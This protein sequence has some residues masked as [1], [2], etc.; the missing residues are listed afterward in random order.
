M[1]FGK[2]L[3]AIFATTVCLTSTNMAVAVDF[4]CVKYEDA[5][6]INILRQHLDNSSKLHYVS[7]K[8]II[9]VQPDDG[10]DIRSL[11]ERLFPPKIEYIDM[12]ESPSGVPLQSIKII[13]PKLHQELKVVLAKYEIWFTT[14]EN[15][16][17]WYEIT[18][19][20]KV[21]DLADRLFK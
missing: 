21:S 17:I 15:D 1:N 13:D 2:V 6:K 9:C 8:T 16:K 12:P 7:D 10:E 4:T 20:E 5:S 14:D 18:N 3:L 19:R 11:A